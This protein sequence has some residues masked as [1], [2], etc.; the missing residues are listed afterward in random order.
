MDYRKEYEKW[1]ES[2]YFDQA[3]TDELIA[4][5]DDEKEIE[6]RFYK[7]LAFG[8]AGMRGKL[9]AGTNRINVYM[10]RRATQGLADYILK[11]GGKERG[12][13]IAY[14]SRHFS[15]V[16]AKETALTFTANGIKAYL[17]T[18]LRPVPVLSY[19]VRHLKTIAGVAITA[20]HN[21]KEY[22][23]YKVYWE[24]GAQAVDEIADE[25]VASVNAIENYD[26]LSVMDE[27]EAIKKGL[28]E[29]I[30]KEVDDAYMADI[31]T[32]SM[33]DGLPKD[34]RIIYTPI[35]GAGNVPVRRILDEL[36]FD[37]VCV[38]KA[39]VEPDGDFPTVKAPNPEDP[40]VFDLAIEYAKEKDAHIILGT[41]PDCD[42]LG[43]LVPDG[44]GGYI[45]LNGNQIGA[46]LFD[47]ILKAK[48]GGL[49]EK[50]VL[51][52]SIVTGDITKHIA[53]K[54]GV[55]TYDVLTGFKYIGEMIEKMESTDETF[56]FGFEESYGYLM[57]AF[58]RDKDAV[59]A[60]MLA[61]EMAAY[62]KS[63][64]KSIYEGL[65]DIYEEY[66][67][68][69]DG[70]I[71]VELDGKAGLDKIGRIMTAFRSEGFPKMPGIKETEAI[72][73]Q[74]QTIRLMEAD[75]VKSTGLRQS[76]VLK[77]VYDDRSWVT[78]RPSG[79]EPKIKVYVSAC[80]KTL[81]GS[82]D[83]MKT[84]MNMMKKAMEQVD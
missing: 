21:P 57:G 2:D 42:R 28:L 62:Y 79:T 23:G 16:F 55:K 67:Y 46:L 10:V 5:K 64:G 69:A 60:S 12:V 4:I 40:A 44:K 37:D 65:M 7:N 20:S 8:T 82:E 80:D 34:F 48:A 51:I 56:I 41:D 84:L 71:A 72:D 74:N 61:C 17:F 24:D 26:S 53:K 15:D 58:A 50:S 78:V 11:Q 76:N 32:L 14:D 59:V 13:A 47:Y 77:R 45:R 54:H 31:K 75:E 27:T 18:S 63:I 68:Y 81:E 1:L 35:H 39:Q 66:G 43:L 38:V 6:D 30:D 70:Q 73:Y 9:G 83:K 22:N 29:Y 19:A 25:I 33:A 36:G 52:K 49:P 3:T